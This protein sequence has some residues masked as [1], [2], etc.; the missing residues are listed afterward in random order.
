[1]D[2][3]P[4]PQ[5][6][7]WT[8]DWILDW[9]KTKMPGKVMVKNTQMGH[10]VP[11]QPFLGSLC[12]NIGAVLLYPCSPDEL[13]EVWGVHVGAFQLGSQALPGA[14]PRRHQRE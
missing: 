7:T 9:T 11:P 5:I 1:M 10:C 8:L 3:G 14:T 4:G 13:S 6:W 2:I 12:Q